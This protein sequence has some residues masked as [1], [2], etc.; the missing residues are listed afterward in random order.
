MWHLNVLTIKADSHG[1]FFY[2]KNASYLK[3]DKEGVAFEAT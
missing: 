2:L 1:I 3:N